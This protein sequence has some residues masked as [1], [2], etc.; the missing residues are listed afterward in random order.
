MK[1][2]RGALI[3]DEKG[4]TLLGFTISRVGPD[5]PHYPPSG[6]LNRDGISGAFYVRED[7]VEQLIKSLSGTAAN[8]GGRD[9]VAAV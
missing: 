1:P 6:H 4:V 8:D 7:E 2:T 5:H 3:G 9:G